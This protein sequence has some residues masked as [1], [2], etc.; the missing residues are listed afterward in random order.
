MPLVR[1]ER[2][3]E[4]ATAAVVREPDDTALE[5]ARVPLRQAEL[6]CLRAARNLADAQVVAVELIREAHG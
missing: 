1:A 4:G 3:V 2:P 6:A 5:R